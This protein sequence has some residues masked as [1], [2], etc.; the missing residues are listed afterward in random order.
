MDLHLNGKTALVTGSYRGTGFAIAEALAREGA[1][2]LLHGFED[3]PTAEA[4]ARLKDAGRVTPVT[5]DLMSDAGAAAL[6]ARCREIAGAPEILVNNYGVAEGGK[7]SDAS[8]DAWHEIYSK[9]VLSA[10]RLS[11]LF[12]PD[13]VASGWGRI[14]MLGTIGSTNPNARMPHYYAAKGALANLTASLAKELSGTG[15]TV[16]LVSPGLIRTAEVE[17]QFLARG[18]REGWGETFEEIEPKVLAQFSGNLTG[19][20]PFPSEIA[21][22]VAFLASPRSGA[23]NCVNYRV[24]G[25]AT[26]LT[27]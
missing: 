16:N 1:H 17:A 19:K 22:L 25:G 11:R 23:I 24:D 12:Y 15:V 20:V 9:N 10:V 4:A 8:T 27:I 18:R 5:G 3:G 6:G 2:V 13:M 7:W 26:A 21:D 14:I